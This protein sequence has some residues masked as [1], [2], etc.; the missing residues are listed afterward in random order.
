MRRGEGIWKE[1]GEDIEIIGVVFLPYLYSIVV[2]VS[3]CLI[4]AGCEYERE[5]GYRVKKDGGC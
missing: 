2:C 4:L 1:G 5:R 3:T